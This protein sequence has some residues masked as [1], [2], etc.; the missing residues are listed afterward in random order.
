MVQPGWL[1]IDLGFGTTDGEFSSWEENKIPFFMILKKISSDE[2]CQTSGQLSH[3]SVNTWCKMAR[4]SATA[5]LGALE[6]T[7]DPYFCF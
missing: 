2:L 4:Q 6:L 5:L 7:S 1:I 3:H